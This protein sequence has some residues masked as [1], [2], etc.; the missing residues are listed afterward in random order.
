VQKI[1]NSENSVWQL[2]AMAVFGVVVFG[3]A[4]GV[5]MQP[6]SEVL[7]ERLGELTCLQVAYSAEKATAIVESFGVAERE[8]MLHLLVPGDL[9]LA[10][11]YGFLLAGLVGLLARLQNGLMRRAGALIMWL[12]LLASVLDSMEDVALYSIVSAL[13]GE[14]SGGISFWQP[15]AAGVFATLK[16]FA[17]C[18]V[19]PLY[20]FVGVISGVKENRSFGALVVYLLVVVSMI[21][22]VMVPIQKIPACF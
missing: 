7:G 6:Y 2:S 22:F 8:A 15:L 12:P 18:V 9:F 20:G 21:S 3:Y 16:Y 10:W 14:S 17:L 13:S 11:G 1:L 4:V 19:T 5:L